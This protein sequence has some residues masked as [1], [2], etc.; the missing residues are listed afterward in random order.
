MRM[1]V[2]RMKHSLLISCFL[3]VLL[4]ISCAVPAFAALPGAANTTASSKPATFAAVTSSRLCGYVKLDNSQLAPAGGYSIKV[5]VAK[6]DGTIVKSTTVKLLANKNSVYYDISYIPNGTYYIYYEMNNFDPKYEPVAYYVLGSSTKSGWMVINQPQY[7]QSL[8][9]QELTNADLTIVAAQ[10]TRSINGTLTLP[11]QIDTDYGL[12]VEVSAYQEIATNS[13]KKYST[14]SVHMDSGQLSASYSI[15]LPN[16]DKKYI[17]KYSLINYPGSEFRT[18]GYYS[19]KGTVP[20]ANGDIPVDKVT[21]LTP[22]L[23]NIKIA[24]LSNVK[25]NATSTITSPANNAVFKYAPTTITGTASDEE[26]TLN[27]VYVVLFNETTGK[28]KTINNSFTTGDGT[29]EWYNI[30]NFNSVNWSL[31]LSGMNLDPGTY[32]IKV[33][34]NDGQPS[35]VPTTSRFVLTTRGNAIA[36]ITSPEDKAV[37]TAGPTSIAGTATDSD[38]IEDLSGVKVEI[39]TNVDGNLMYLDTSTK[40]WKQV[41]TIYNEAAYSNGSWSLDLS[42]IEFPAGTY[43]VFAYADDGVRG[44]QSQMVTFTVQ[45]E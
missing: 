27:S 22:S 44:L 17:V 26:T 13:F 19:S 31:S 36:A 5:N 11:S 8:Y 25:G 12:N 14:V 30:A 42:G 32:L 1:K 7:P 39:R 35:T 2:K 24:V 41:Y 3:S 15:P 33:Y 10:T 43:F 23:T 6:A 40:T 37:L 20:P 18:E 9:N 38:G 28:Y 4:V 29:V 21:K 45:P 16:Q 34:A